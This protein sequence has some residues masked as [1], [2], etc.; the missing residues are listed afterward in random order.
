MMRS[1]AVREGAVG[2]LMLG[3]ALSF[4]GLFVWLYNFQFGSEGYQFTVRY[5]EG[6]SGLSRGANV[7]LRGVT[8][9]RVESVSP[10]VDAVRVE[11]QVNGLTPVPRR[12][13][14]ITS[15]TG[16]VGETI[17]EIFPAP[18]LTISGDPG[19]PLAADC[20]N[21][22]SVV[23][24]GD[25]I[26]G[27]RGVDYA[28]L[29]TSVDQLSSRINNDEFFGNLNKTLEGITEVTNEVA[30]LSTA[31][32]T[33]LG[34]VDVEDLDLS[35]VTV[36]AESI[37]GTAQ[38]LEQLTQEASELVSGNRASL[39]ASV[40]NI[41]NL[42]ADAQA[43][44]DALKPALTDPALQSDLKTI[45]AN[46]SAAS[47]NLS[48]ASTNAVTASEEI[49]ATL[50]ELNDPTTLATLR[51]ALDS[52][53]VTFQN[54]EKITADIDELTGDPGFRQNLRDLVNGL[55]S[56]VSASPTES[57]TQPVLF[58]DPIE[59]EYPLRLTQFEEP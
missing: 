26:T 57:D 9:G 37:S 20:S 6:V 27:V 45:L 4:A 50:G 58:G 33:T 55:S 54:T 18:D 44:T 11:V 10:G 35:Q 30:E 46:L 29:L 39:E 34:Q 8:I 49:N 23:C 21:T 53:R 1:R 25:E 56:L 40:Q 19:S 38:S 3:G 41:Q 22:S 51:Q 14:F 36:A 7:R 42:T 43:I 12:S 5:D 28:D 48:T 17:L 15:Q 47:A 2:L 13:T 31:L 52:A 16:L 59:S 32:Q 24:D